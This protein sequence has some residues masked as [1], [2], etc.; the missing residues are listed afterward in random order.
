MTRYRVTYIDCAL[1]ER[2]VEAQSAEDAE[3]TVYD[4]MSDAVHHHIA[5]AWIDDLSASN[6]SATEPEKSGCHECGH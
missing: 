5:D 3:N 1:R 2:F 4:E 6:V